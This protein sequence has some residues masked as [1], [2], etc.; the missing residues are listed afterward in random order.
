MLA[1]AAPAPAGPDDVATIS[2]L[3]Q[4]AGAP[5]RPPLEFAIQDDPEFLNHPER[6]DETMAEV[7]E[8]GF[9]H[10]RLSAH[11]DQL[12][13][14]PGATH[15]PRFAAASPGAYDQRRWSALDRAVSAAARHGLSVMIDVAFYAPRWATTG[16]DRF[17]PRPRNRI[18]ARDFTNFAVAIARRY[19]GRFATSPH[20]RQALPRVSIFT[21]WNEP[22]LAVFWTPQRR[23]LRGGRIA[24][25]SPHAYRRLVAMAYPAI[26]RNR[27]DATV[28]VGGLAS[29]QAW[30]PRARQAGIPAM[31][32]IREM[33]CVD[34]ALR[35]LHTP[36]CARFHRVPGDGLAA[37]P[38]SLG[39][40]PDYRPVGDRVDTLTMGNLGRLALLLRRLAAR[41]RIAPGLQY[42]YLTEFGYLTPDR[43][44]RGLAHRNPFPKVTPAQ[45]GTLEARAHELA[46]LQPQVRMFA[47]FLVRDT[48]CALGS[49]IECVDWTSGFRYADGLAKPMVSALGAA[50]LVSRRAGGITDVWGRLGHPELRRSAVL[51]YEQAG[52]WHP[53]RND[54]VRSFSGGGPDGIFAARLQGPATSR[55]RIATR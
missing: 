10:V 7:R 45:Q 29:G 18:N 32:F 39:H 21:L 52:T 1:L 44:A 55:F 11:W 49:G 35:P 5:P 27:P 53:V 43:E 46:W 51:E 38:Y 31:R 8:L 22:N 20:A 30:M 24:L 34:T 23:V 33:A 17:G 19:S 3:A 26:K 42:V 9:T 12:T 50:L 13:R 41:G 4:G 37:H 15:R 2:S 14:A 47:H 54:E 6:L 40:P 28:L 36:D 16:P 25:D 48:D